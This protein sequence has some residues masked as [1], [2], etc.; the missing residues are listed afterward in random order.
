MNPGLTL[1]R[2]N[3]VVKSIRLL[4]QMCSG[5]AV[6]WSVFSTTA[7]AQGSLTPPGPPAPTMKTLDQIEPRTPISSLPYTIS[8]PGSY[9]VTSN[10]ST[11]VNQNGII[12]SADNVTIDLKGFTL[13]GG[14]GISG[15]AIWTPAA[16][17]NIVVRN[18]SLRSW[19]GSGV[20]FYDGN[21]SQTIVENVQSISNG[22]TGIAVRNGGRVI[23]CN[24][25]GNGLRGIIVDND[26]LVQNC[27]AQ[28]SGIFGIGA[29]A[30]CRIL[31][32]QITANATGLNISG[33]NNLVSGNL[34]SSN[35][36]NYGIVQG[37]QLD[38]LLCQLPETISWP[39]KVKLV[40][41]LN[42]TVSNG[43]TIAANDVTL[44]LN[45]F[46]ISST[47]PSATGTAILINSGLKNISIANGFIQGGVTNNGGVY[48][49]TGFSR[50]IYYSGNEPTSVL[51]SKVSISGC[52][53]DGINLGLSDYFGASTWSAVEDCLVETVGGV[54]IETETVKNSIGRNC[55]SLGIFGHTVTGSYGDSRNGGGI[56]AVIVE[57]S[58]GASLLYV[59]VTADEAQNSEGI[60]GS[61]TGLEATTAINCSGTCING[62][63][64]A[65]LSATVAMNCYGIMENFSN[66]TG[67]G[68]YAMQIATG[69]YG[70]ASYGTGLSAFLANGC[71][72][73][74]DNIGTG[75][76]AT[77]NVNSF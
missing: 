41:P 53:S 31:N 26:T 36:S 62:N 28:G 18:G 7:H 1:N 51:V 39:A 15:E 38:I 3:T 54:G 42:V 60:T 32:N 10:L 45:G 25:I 17:V 33:A 13:I 24:T 49:G 14:G 19:P 67:Y 71:H 22:F 4:I 6:W 34:V 50:G 66:G 5:C 12:V 59:G 48:S 27:K 23:D 55:G 37:N 58:Y 63:G 73:V 40:G 74:V 30:N 70:E 72:G 65:G 35:T 21:S 69:C 8:T 75:L 2:R 68:L 11:G 9:Y 20:N 29:G 64:S 57:N 44:D 46:T 76:S 47:A 61:G 77:H 43:V 52:L 56:E 16:Q